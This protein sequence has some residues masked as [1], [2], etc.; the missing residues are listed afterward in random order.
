MP[1]AL[2]LVLPRKKR[3]DHARV[4]FEERGGKSLVFVCPAHLSTR[5]GAIDIGIAIDK[6]GG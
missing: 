2:G 1:T 3:S 5:A 6:T 4:M